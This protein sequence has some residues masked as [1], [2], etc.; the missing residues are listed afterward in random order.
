ME[1]ERNASKNIAWQEKKNKKIKIILRG[2]I[3]EN[4]ASDPE[5]LCEARIAFADTDDPDSSGVSSGSARHRRDR[6]RHN[7]VKK[8]EKDL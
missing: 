5:T 3:L 7:L 1:L 2:K 6:K 8:K 4:F